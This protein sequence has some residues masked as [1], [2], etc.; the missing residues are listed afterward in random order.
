MQSS[1]TSQISPG[2]RSA[3]QTGTPGPAL[4]DRSVG[5]PARP[6]ADGFRVARRDAHEAPQHLPDLAE[7]EAGVQVLDEVEHIA[8][9]VAGRVPPAVA[10]MVDDDDLAGSTAI[11]QGPFRALTHIQFP[12]AHHSF[13]D[14]RAVHGL[15]EQLQLRIGGCRHRVSPG[16]AGTAGGASCPALS[17]SGISRRPATAK[18]EGCKGAASCGGCAAASL[19]ARP[20]Q[21]VASF[22]CVVS[23]MPRVVQ[24]ELANGASFREGVSGRQIRKPHSRGCS[25]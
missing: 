4:R 16:L 18:P 24:G 6:A 2:I 13:E 15:A 1:L 10:V 3:P 14:S 25:V 21:A 12:A 20:A 22:C 8:L 5:F 19:A 11:F 9:G 23:V 17:I 7:V